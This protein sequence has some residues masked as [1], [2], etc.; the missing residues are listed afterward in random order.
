[1]CSI[2]CYWHTGGVA[3]GRT[4]GAGS[5]ADYVCRFFSPWVGISEDHATGSLAT[6]LG[7][8]H[9]AAGRGAQGVKLRSLQLSQRP[10]QL[11]VTVSG[12]SVT[13]GG[14]A[15]VVLDGRLLVQV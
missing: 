6:V 13:V 7:P 11:D 12:D 1:M 8:L 9:L 4:G 14:H 10:S 15:H 5:D 2:A 3:D